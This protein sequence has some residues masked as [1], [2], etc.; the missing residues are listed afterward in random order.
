MPDV[1]YLDDRLIEAMQ[2]GDESALE[3]VIDKYTAYVGTIVWNLVKG[4]LT[5][6][7]AKEILSD[8]FFTLWKNSSK[9]RKGKLKAYLGSIARTKALDALRHTRR[10]VFLDDETREYAVSGPEDA[11]M[12]TEARA[13]LYQALDSLQEPE[14]SILIRHYCKNQKTR[15][16]AEQMGLK[17]KTVQTK[18]RRGREKLR[19]MLAE[20]GYFI[21]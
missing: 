16:I 14:R 7:D 5:E 21:E 2:N 18:L 9:V 20:G 4:V 13:L 19:S 6:S 17:T 1:I 3:Y 15:V 10:E 8:V 12:K 11:L